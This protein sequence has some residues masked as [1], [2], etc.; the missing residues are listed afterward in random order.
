MTWPFGD[1]QPQTYRALIVDPP[2]VFSAGT[3]GRPQH[4]DRMTDAQ[5]ARLPVDELA[6]PDGC[7][8]FLWTT[9]PRLALTFE[10]VQHWGFRY[11]ARAFVWVKTSTDGRRLHLGQ[12]F[13]TR[14]NAEDC[15]LFRRGS[16]Q[17]AAKDVGEIIIAPARE[18]SRK[19]DQ[20][21][22]RVERFCPG[23]YAELFSRESRPGWDAYG[24]E[25][26]KFDRP[27][28]AAAAE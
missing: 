4:Y 23:P 28:L 27:M 3:K 16:P 13:T 8:L 6:H 7:W 15:L 19:P 12:G 11:S 18:H 22:E 21:Y 25:A 9:S 17:R 26:G 20:A 1:L 24:R 14:K 2:W 10:V 5:I